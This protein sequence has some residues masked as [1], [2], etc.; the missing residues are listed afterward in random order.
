MTGQVF[1]AALASDNNYRVAIPA[2]RT[3]RANIDEIRPGW[4][5]SR[6]LATRDVCRGLIAQSP[7][8]QAGGGFD[9]YRQGAAV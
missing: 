1:Y 9:G 5:L 2:S 3:P 7:G 8:K 4:R 6:I